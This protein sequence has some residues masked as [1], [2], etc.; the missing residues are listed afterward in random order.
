MSL[1]CGVTRFIVIQSMCEDVQLVTQLMCEDVQR[2]ACDS[3][4][5]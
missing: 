3:V 5:V 2:T 4:D 1:L